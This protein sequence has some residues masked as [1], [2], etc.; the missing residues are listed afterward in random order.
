MRRFAAYLRYLTLPALLLLSACFAVV[1]DESSPFFMAPPGSVVV[2]HQDLEVPPGTAS[3]YI[4][5]GRITSRAAYNRYYP[6]CRFEVRDVSEQPQIIRAGQFRVEKT[7]RE[8]DFFAEAG[9]VRYARLGLGQDSDGASLE[10]EVVKMRLRSATQPEVLR[11]VCGG[12][13]DFPFNV[14]P[15][16]IQEIRGTLGE[17]VSLEL[18]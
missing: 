14:K 12:V 7:T 16:S 15:P 4:Q 8:T 13:M 10:M 18:P 9:I 5:R 17:F 1:Q 2:L 3:V 6:H 11:F